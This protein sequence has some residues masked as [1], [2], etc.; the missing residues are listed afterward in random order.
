MRGLDPRIHRSS[1]E[2]GLPPGNDEE[3]EPETKEKT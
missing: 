3:R 2:D 1:Q